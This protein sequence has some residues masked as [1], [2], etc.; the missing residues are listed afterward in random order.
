VNAGERIG[1]FEMGSS[2][3]VL[4]E[5]RVN[6]ASQLKEEQKIKYGALIGL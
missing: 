1:T 6:F 2:V 3:V 4:V 5:K